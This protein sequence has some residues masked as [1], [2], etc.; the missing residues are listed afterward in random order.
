[1][2]IKKQDFNQSAIS[3]YLHVLYDIYHNLYLIAI[4]PINSIIKLIL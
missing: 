2:H 4:N 1:M 3:Y